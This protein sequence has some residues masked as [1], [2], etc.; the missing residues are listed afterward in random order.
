MY[1]GVLTVAAA[2]LAVERLAYVWI[3]RRPDTLER[4]VARW[5]L[6]SSAGAINVLAGLC[7]VFKVLQL[8]V[9]FVWCSIATNLHPPHAWRDHGAVV[10]GAILIVT[11]QL[12]NLRVF[13]LLG[14]TGVFYGDRFGVQLP[15]R[16][17][18]PFSIMR[19]PQYVGACMSVWGFFLVMRFPYDDWYV[20]PILE[21]AYYAAG[22]V[23]ER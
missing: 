9:F 22:S 7:V 19:H 1:P 20:L 10:A 12:L 11:G 18:F 4:L 13:Q 15:W 8:T 17:D 2:A 16:T 6:L 23:L 3:S 14:R 21:T 5:S